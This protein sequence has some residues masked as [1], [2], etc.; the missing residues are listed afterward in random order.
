MSVPS[1]LRMDNTCFT[2]EKELWM[3]AGFDARLPQTDQYNVCQTVSGN[4]WLNK[5]YTWLWKLLKLLLLS[6]RCWLLQEC[7]GIAALWLRGAIL[8]PAVLYPSVLTVFSWLC[9]GMKGKETS[10][11]LMI[12][13]IILLLQRLLLVLV[14]FCTIY[15]VCKSSDP[16][17]V[18]NNSQAV[19]PSCSS[20][21]LLLWKQIVP[22]FIGRI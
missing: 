21:S 8:P 12:D 16:R 11:D 6:C 5:G 9:A 1:K 18:P 19:C 13:C 14:T 4:S 15:V 20:L 10:L 2:G 17:C 7:S 3:D 22:N